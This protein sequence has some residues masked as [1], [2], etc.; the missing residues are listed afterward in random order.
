MYPP[1]HS[2]W[3][4]YGGSA[5]PK[6]ALGFRPTV[7]N[8]TVFLQVGEKAVWFSDRLGKSLLN[9]ALLATSLRKAA[10]TGHWDARE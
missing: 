5:P 4:R 10:L 7:Q 9:A 8:H 1:E 6:S 2:I 3:G